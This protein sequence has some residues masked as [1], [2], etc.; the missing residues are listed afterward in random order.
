[1]QDSAEDVSP[2]THATSIDLRR[3]ER[4]DLI[5]V[6]TIAVLLLS[7]IVTLVV[8]DRAGVAVTVMTPVGSA[9]TISPI[10]IAFGEPMNSASVESKFTIDPQVKGTFSWSNMQLTFTP[11][12]PFKSGQQYTVTIHEG[13]FSQQGRILTDAVQW[14]FETT[15]S[16]VVYLAPAVQDENAVGSTAPNLWMVETGAPFTGTQLT[17]SRS[18]ILPDYSVSPDGTRIAYAE[19]GQPA[20]DLYLYSIDSATSQRITQC[21]DAKCQAPEWSPDGTR[22]I[23]ER[24]ELNANLPDIDRGVPRAWIVNLSDLS[25]A[26]LLPSSQLLSKA[27]H[28]SPNG[29][30]ISLYDMT[31]HAITIYNTVSG[32][33]KL[34][35]TQETDSGTF[36]PQGSRLIFPELRQS[37]EGFFTTLTIADLATPEK[38]LKPLTSINNE[39]VED[40]GAAWKPDGTQI[41]VTRRYF[42][43]SQGAQIYLINPDSGDE[44]QLV[45]DTNYNHGAVSWSPAGDQLVMQRYPLFATNPVPGIWVYDIETKS[46]AHIGKNG[47]LPKWL[48]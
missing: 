40:R 48:P 35:P 42:G 30:D 37:P 22:L 6:V 7:L 8:G 47:Y 5:M 2:Q 11:D 43:K 31:A 24:I 19:A 25:T 4:F 14:Q 3:I 17:F 26:P 15:P 16:R 13:A 46:I 39:P 20:T 27:P 18:G 33:R 29:T 9:H 28:W 12:I 36:D 41:A 38:G 32:D 34:I 21:I 45:F 23:Y 1:L 10:R 44:Q